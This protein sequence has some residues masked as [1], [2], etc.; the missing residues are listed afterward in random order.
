[1]DDIAKNKFVREF[2]EFVRNPS[3]HEYFTFSSEFNKLSVEER[4]AALLDIIII[5]SLLKFLELDIDGDGG[6]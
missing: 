1:M 3:G 2:I 4:T 5:L 6:L